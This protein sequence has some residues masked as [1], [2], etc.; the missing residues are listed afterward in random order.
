MHRQKEAHRFYSSENML[1][2][3]G[4][5]KD[6]FKCVSDPIKRSGD[7]YHYIR[8]TYPITLGRGVTTFPFASLSQ[9]LLCTEKGRTPTERSHTQNIKRLLSQRKLPTSSHMPM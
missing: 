1:Q 7:N 4:N 5:V 9:V 6:T 3:E 8:G 2:E